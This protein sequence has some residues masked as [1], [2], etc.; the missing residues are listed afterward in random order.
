MAAEDN[1][2]RLEEAKKQAKEQPKKAE[3]Q[4]K[5]ILSQPPGTNDKAVREFEGALIGLGELY[6]DH[7]RTNDLANLI[8]QTRD[9]LTS[10]ARAKTS[11]L[12]TLARD[13]AV[14]MELLTMA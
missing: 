2:K 13:Y 6:R 8:Q 12:G 7:Q 4:Y 11:K 14:A 10:F 3:E 1:A 9:V 5:A